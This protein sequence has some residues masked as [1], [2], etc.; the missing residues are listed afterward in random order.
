V[1]AGKYYVQA[2]T[3]VGGGDAERPEIRSDGT[4]AAIYATT[5]YPSSI[6][7]ERGKVVEVA[8]GKEA[9]GIEIRLA[10]QQ[11]LAI[12]GV[13]SG[14]PEGALGA[15]IV[16]EFEVSEQGI[17]GMIRTRSSA[18][19][20][21]RFDRLQ[22]GFYQLRAIF[23]KG[24]T[25]LVSRSIERQIGNLEIANVELV[26]DASV[27]LSGTLKMEGEGAGAAT[28]KRTVKLDPVEGRF[29]GQMTG[30]EVDRD[31]AFRIANIV[32]GK[33]LVRLQG[34]TGNAYVKTLEIDGMAASFGIADLSHVARGATAKVTVGINGAQISGRVLDANGE[35]MV[36][37]TVMI[38]LARDAEHIPLYGDGRVQPTLDGKYKVKA[39][40]PGKYRLFAVNELQI[41]GSGDEDTII[42]KMF[43]RGEEIEFKEGDRIVKDLSVIPG[44][45]PNAKPKK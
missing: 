37:D 3:D 10:R 36:S 29:W 6:R 31:G 38:Y 32:P 4:S 8:A 42:K 28:P 25:L 30:G 35:P 20:K 12:S 24:K 7:E 1:P 39:V 43:E 33:Y 26:L 34:L 19:G 9:G 16:A 18:D 45:D 13:V 44:E 11:G 15:N 27:E 5:F 23:E 2:T 14:I 22:P 21:F 17:T 41:R 40:A